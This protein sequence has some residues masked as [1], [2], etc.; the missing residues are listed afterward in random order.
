MAPGGLEQKSVRQL[1][2]WCG[3]AGVKPA[4][5]FR[6]EGFSYHFGFHRLAWA[7]SRLRLVRGLD[8]NHH[9]LLTREP[10]NSTRKV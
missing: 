2:N 5:L 7:R 8:Y 6:A 4:Q 3:L 1:L 10:Y 9:V